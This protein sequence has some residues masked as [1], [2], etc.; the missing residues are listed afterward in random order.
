LHVRSGLAGK[1]ERLTAVHVRHH[2]GQVSH[3]DRRATDV[4]IAEMLDLGPVRC[5]CQ[6]RFGFS[7]WA[8]LRT[9][10]QL[11]YR[12]GKF[13]FTGTAEPRATVTLYDTDGTVLGRATAD[14]QAA[15]AF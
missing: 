11:R 6:C 3:V 9:Q 4:A 5:R 12:D 13:V 1:V 7:S 2:L 15:P 14:A 8:R 10:G